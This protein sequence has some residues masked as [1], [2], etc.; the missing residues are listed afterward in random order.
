MN[1]TRTITSQLDDIQIGSGAYIEFS[2][3]EPVA[4]MII[5]R[6]SQKSGHKFRLIKLL[7]GWY[8][9]RTA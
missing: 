3:S 4:R 5:Y 1:M 6:H 9:E 7:A 2:C 8:A